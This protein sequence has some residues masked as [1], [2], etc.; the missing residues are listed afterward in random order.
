[1]LLFSDL[2]TSIHIRYFLH[3]YTQIDSWHLSMTA[4]QTILQDITIIIIIMVY[5]VLYITNYIS[6]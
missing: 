1:M 5:G 3:S 6:Y 4:I 2:P